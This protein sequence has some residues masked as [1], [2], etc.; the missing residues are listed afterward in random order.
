MPT[1]SRVLVAIAAGAAVIGAGGVAVAAS[2]REGVG[3]LLPAGPLSARRQKVLATL[4]ELIPS[5]YKDPQ[6][7]DKFMAIVGPNYDPDDPKLPPGYTTCGALP[8][9]IGQV[10][11]VAK[12]YCITQGGLEQMRTNG[13]AIG[14]WIEPT[15]RNRPRP[16]DLYG[17]G[18]QDI[19][20]HVG[21]FRRRVDLKEE[22]A[23]LRAN[24]APL[25]GWLRKVADDKAAQV[26]RWIAQGYREGWE[27]GDTG[28][29]SREIQ[30][31]QFV[32]RPYDPKTNSL[33]SAIDGKSRPVAGWYDIDKA[34]GATP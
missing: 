28:Q 1:S 16:G 2:A 30:E 19:I 4:E 33:V 5:K 3:S 15:G 12:P 31:A 11:G 14:A 13:R 32:M 34:P 8:C 18:G 24:A 7:H 26:E 29:G 23:K 21:V 17:V 10:L 6:T 22:L 27:T 20:K 9:K 25:T